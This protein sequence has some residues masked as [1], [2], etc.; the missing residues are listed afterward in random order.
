M[1]SQLPNAGK[2]NIYRP[3]RK[4]TMEVYID[5]MLVKL[6]IGFQCIMKMCDE[7]QFS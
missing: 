5:D 2:Q 3:I 1:R 7:T 6:R 4:K